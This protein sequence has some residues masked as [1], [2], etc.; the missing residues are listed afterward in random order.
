MPQ[1]N[2]W[3]IQKIN[4]WVTY[5]V[6]RKINDM[7]LL[8]LF[9]DTFFYNTRQNTEAIKCKTNLTQLKKICID[10]GISINRSDKEYIS[11]HSEYKVKAH[12]Q[13]GDKIFKNGTLYNILAI[14]PQFIVTEYKE[15]S[16]EGK[17]L[18]GEYAFI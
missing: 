8:D 13:V 2:K 12:V 16:Q 7:K 10:M 14:K 1:L 3:D 18:Q 15:V 17:I 5:N 11:F 4:T 9:N 6:P